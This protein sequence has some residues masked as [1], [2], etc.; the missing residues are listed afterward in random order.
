MAESLFTGAE[1]LGT[2]D[3]TGRPHAG[4]GLPLSFVEHIRQVLE[5]EIIGGSIE[6]GARVT[7][8]ELARHVGVSRTPVREA[9][10]SLESQ[11]LIE[12]RRGRSISV[13]E[14]TTPRE[15]EALYEVRVVLEGHLAATA[16]ERIGDADLETV[17]ASQRKF[18]AVLEQGEPLERRKLIA[19]DSDLHWTIYNAAA[20]NLTVILASYWGRLQRELYDPV[21]RSSPA[22]FADQHDEIIGALANHRPEEAREAMAVHVRTGWAAIQECYGDA[23]SPASEGEAT[24]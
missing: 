15:A 4:R 1:S 7:E 10:R 6:P 11:G 2:Y 5:A 17:A 23:A 20:S 24:S 18:R 9:M 21:Y 12:R 19:L 14:R 3:A 13:S 8:D 16:A 22:L